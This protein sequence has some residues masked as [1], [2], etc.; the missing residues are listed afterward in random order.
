MIDATTKRLP[1]ATE[2]GVWALDLA[3]RIIRNGRDGGNALLEQQR[4]ALAAYEQEAL[5]DGN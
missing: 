1:T 4:E 3:K 2:R 5:T